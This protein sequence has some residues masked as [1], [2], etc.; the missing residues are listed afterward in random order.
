MPDQPTAFLAGLLLPLVL[1]LASCGE[2]GP[3]PFSKSAQRGRVVFLQRSNPRCG[4]CHRLGD[5]NVVGPLGPDLDVL[6]PTRDRIIQAV[7]HGVKVMPP[8]KGVLSPGEIQDVSA[9]VHEAAG[10]ER[11]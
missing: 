6:R 8:Q 2:S 10:R 11:R 4:I 1:G 5:A 7:T 3:K 9:Y